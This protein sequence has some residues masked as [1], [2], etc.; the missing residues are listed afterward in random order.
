MRPFTVH[1]GKKT[2]H[3]QQLH[4]YRNKRTNKMEY[5]GCRVERLFH[6]HD[7]HFVHLYKFEFIICAVLLREC[8]AYIDGK[9]KIPF[10][11]IFYQMKM[12]LWQHTKQHN[13]HRIKGKIIEN[14]NWFF[15][16]QSECLPFVKQ[17]HNFV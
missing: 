1:S 16:L 9:K 11:A 3:I 4:H 5:I 13:G 17:V 6:L 8:C 12:R 2:L 15:R 7:N 14:R 10:F